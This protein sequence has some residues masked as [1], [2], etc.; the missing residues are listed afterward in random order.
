M[1][2]T[3]SILIFDSY[4]GIERTGGFSGPRIFIMKNLRNFE[5]VLIFAVGFGNWFELTLALTGPAIELDV[6]K[7]YLQ[8]V[9]AP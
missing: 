8:V 2:R 3:S 7:A 5:L 6:Q 9:T 4:V 1:T